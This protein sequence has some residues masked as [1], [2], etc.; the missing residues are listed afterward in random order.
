VSMSD[1]QWSR[2]MRQLKVRDPYR[3]EVVMAGVP[4]RLV[5]KFMNLPRIV[6]DV[7]RN[8]QPMAPVR[9]AHG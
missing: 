1:A 9:I 5:N 7:W 3:Y 2:C 4:P 8:S 6:L